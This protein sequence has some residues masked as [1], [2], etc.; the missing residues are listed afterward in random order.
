MEIQVD[1]KEAGVALITG[2]IVE[3]WLGRQPIAKGAVTAEQ[4]SDVIIC[5][6]IGLSTPLHSLPA[7]TDRPR[8]HLS[9]V[10]P[11]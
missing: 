11:A 10:D 3:A 7:Q 4:L 5:V 1:S 2:Q 6:R 9:L 8:S